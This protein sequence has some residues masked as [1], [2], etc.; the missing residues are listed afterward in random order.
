MAWRGL[1]ERAF[2][3]GLPVTM[4]ASVPQ[5]QSSSSVV[6]AAIDNEIVEVECPCVRESVVVVVVG[7]INA[8]TDSRAL[9]EAHPVKYIAAAA[10]ADFENFILASVWLLPQNWNERMEANR[11]WMANGRL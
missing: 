10:A 5:P 1:R 3:V 4:V 7:R 6:D 2:D 9:F 8:S 11:Q